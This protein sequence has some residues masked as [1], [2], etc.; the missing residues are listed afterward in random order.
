MSDNDEYWRE[1]QLYKQIKELV[2]ACGGNPALVAA[3][4]G[5]QLELLGVPF[6][7]FAQALANAIAVEQ[8]RRRQH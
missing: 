5:E 4:L 7:M 3:S 1:R 6:P 8:L 2:G